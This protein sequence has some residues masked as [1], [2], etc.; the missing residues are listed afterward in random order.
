LFRSVGLHVMPAPIPVAINPPLLIWAREE[1]G[2]PVERVAKGI[3]VKEERILEWERGERQPSM[4]QVENLAKL[5]HRPLSVFFLPA[6]P[7]LTPLAA[8]YRRLPKVKPGMESPE[9]RLALRQMVLRRESALELMDD[10]GEQATPFTLSAQQHEKPEAVAERLRT[11]L[12]I[13]VPEQLAWPNEWQA[14]NAWRDAAE[15][16]GVLVFQFSKVPLDEARGLA[17]VRTPMPVVGINSKEMAE[18]KAYT[19]LHEVVHLML[20]SANEEESALNERRTDTEWASVERFAEQVASQ[21][22]VP[23]HAIRS[24]V[25]QMGLTNGPW[26]FDNIRKL[27]RRF[28]ITPMATATRLASSG[29]MTWPQYN[30]WRKGWDEYVSTLPKRK[31]GVA[32]QAQKAVN[33]NGRPYTTLVLG[34]LAANHITSVD[35][36]RYLHLKFHHFDELRTRLVQG[37]GNVAVNE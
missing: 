11:A 37:P 34:A 2:Y 25:T 1:S 23:E 7:K 13:T 8:E 5:F 20:V 9:L 26:N 27:A 36:A 31:G 28:R 18:A 24:M 29:Y 15:R 22:L 19:L 10:L 14:W 4:R 17:L 6:P 32:T 21:A 16:I 35:A 3:Q 30:A 33:R 12:G